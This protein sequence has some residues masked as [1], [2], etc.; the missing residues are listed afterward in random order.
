M[1]AAPA[2]ANGDERVRV[3]TR[4]V[5]LGADLSPAIGASDLCEA[6]DGA[7]EIWNEV[8]R[9]DFRERAVPL[10]RE[11][12]RARPHLVG[13]QE[14]AL[15]RTQTP[16]DNGGPPISPDPNATSATTV[17][18]DFLKLL[19]RRLGKRY[20]VVGV[21][22]EFD[23]ELPANTD[24]QATGGV[25]G[26]DLDARLTMRDVILARRGVKTSRLRKG[27]YENRY[28]AEISGIEVPADRGWL[29]TRAKVGDAKFRFVN[30]H[31]EAFGDPRIRR[32]QAKELIDAALRGR[33]QVVL[34]G[35]LNSGLPKRHRIG[36]GLTDSPR[37]PLAFRALKRFGM[38]DRGA[39][40][41]CCYPSLLNDPDY[42]F[43]H[44]VDHVLV[45]RKARRV[46]AF[47]TG[48]DPRQMTPSGLWPSDHGGVVSTL[49][50]R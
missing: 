20:R 41:S 21:Q 4:N 23:A 8:Q 18:Y 27:H 12:K 26:A 32:D 50:L 16:S 9:T 38:K 22:N 17:A 31:L 44:T 43:D 3:M 39:V 36:A 28:V 35:D 34:V 24:G 47:V 5:Y 30:T 13:L 40:Q 46:N 7:G 10:A 6:I 11:I 14:V 15:W 1:L 25:C 2:V 37:D 29:S 19:K 33:G 45:K 42:R 49:L 48:N